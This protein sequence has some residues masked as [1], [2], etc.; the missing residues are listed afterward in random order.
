M[1][2]P[3]LVHDRVDTDPVDAAGAEQRT[4]RVQDALASFGLLLVWLS[5]AWL[6]PVWLLWARRTH[7]RASPV[8]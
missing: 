6:S 7:G 1:G 8:T 5:P 2:Q 4:G 3:G